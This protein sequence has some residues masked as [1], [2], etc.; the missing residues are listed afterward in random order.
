MMHF[1]SDV[2]FN[3]LATGVEAGDIHI[4]DELDDLLDYSLRAY[5]KG[6]V[7][8]A[9]L[10]DVMQDIKLTVWKYL[11]S[12]LDNSRHKSP[13]QRNAWLYK[14]AE[15][16]IADH[17]RRQAA[18]KGMKPTR[19]IADELPD[20]ASEVQKTEHVAVEFIAEKAEYIPEHV[21]L[22]SVE[23]QINRKKCERIIEFICSMGLSPERII[24]VLYNSIVF[25]LNAERQNGFPQTLVT[26]FTGMNLWDIRVRLLH[27]MSDTLGY[28]ISE[29][30][31]LALDEKLKRLEKTTFDMTAREI[32][33]ATTNIRRAT[34]ERHEKILGGSADE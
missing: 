23:Q 11:A 21:V 20:T 12:Y 7:P 8:K 24:A 27:D 1:G 28:P 5:V 6:N 29:S 13:E 17:Y 22:S 4:Y 18:Q 34:R 30:V 2:F 14:I 16:R 15:S 10:D 9:D 19:N 31:F 25:P 26:E 33:L 32:T 3:K